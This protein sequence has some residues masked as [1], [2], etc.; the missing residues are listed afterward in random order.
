MNSAKIMELFPLR[1]VHTAAQY[2]AKRSRMLQITTNMT[3]LDGTLRTNA[4]SRAPPRTNK[5][6]PLVVGTSK[7]VGR[8]VWTEN[9]SLPKPNAQ[10]ETI[11]PFDFFL[12]RLLHIQGYSK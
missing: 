4:P 12:T 7:K 1:P 9:S 6:V 11:F 5:Y 3:S 2:R 10:Q 8:S